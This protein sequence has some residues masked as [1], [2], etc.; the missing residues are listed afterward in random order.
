MFPVV[1]N[2][3][4]PPTAN[5][6]PLSVHVVGAVNVTAPVTTL[7]SAVERRPV[8]WVDVKKVVTVDSHLGVGACH[9]LDLPH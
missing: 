7:S 4:F 1:E 2:T 8:V 5:V 6:W 3:T 9:A